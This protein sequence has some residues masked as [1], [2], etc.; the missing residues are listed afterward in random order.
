MVGP[1]PPLEGGGP[2]GAPPGIP[3]PPGAAP[4]PPAYSF[5]MIGLKICS[6]SFC[7]SSYSSFS[8]VW[9]LSNHLIHS[10]HLSVIVFFSESEIAV[11]TFSSSMVDFMLKQ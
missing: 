9:L 7:L 10:S 5:W 4:A 6:N 2:L 8:A 3:P 11:L 1:A